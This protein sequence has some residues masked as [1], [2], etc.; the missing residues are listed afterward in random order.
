MP[1]SSMPG[2]K[3]TDLEDSFSA[4]DFSGLLGWLRGKIHIHGMRYRA[5]ELVKGLQG[6]PL[7]PIFPQLPVRTLRRPL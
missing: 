3:S 5:G 2:K 6:V 7:T 1:P 4:G